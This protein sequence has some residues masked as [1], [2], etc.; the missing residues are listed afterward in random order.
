MRSE[1]RFRRARATRVFFLVRRKAFEKIFLTYF[2]RK[3]TS[4]PPPLASK[5]IEGY[6]FIRSCNERT[7]TLEKMYKGCPPPATHK[8]SSSVRSAGTFHTPPS[9]HLTHDPL[10]GAFLGTRRRGAG[11]RPRWTQRP[12]AEF[13][14]LF[15]FVWKQSV[16]LLSPSLLSL[17][18]T[19]PPLFVRHKTIVFYFPPRLRI[20]EGRLY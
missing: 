12:Y 11:D 14:L 9:G 17:S 18:L 5:F 20:R 3:T 8:L 19:S 16:F 1:K 6:F 15:F 4:P 13:P 7:R 2:V 10:W